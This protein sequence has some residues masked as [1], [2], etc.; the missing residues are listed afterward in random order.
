MDKTKAQLVSVLIPS[1][2]HSKYIVEC[3]ESIKS[4]DYSLLELIVI[5]D[6]STDVSVDIINSWLSCNKDYFERTVFVQQKNA[7]ICKTLNNLIAL[8]QG[9]FLVF[10]ASD[11][12]ILPEGISQRVAAL[13]K[14]ISW[15]AVYGDCTLIDSNSEIISKSAMSYLYKV[16]KLAL[17]NSNYIAREL[18]LNWSVPGPGFMAKKECY[19][20]SRGVGLYNEDL[21]FEDRD[22]YLRLLSKNALG[23]IDFSVAAYRLHGFNISR[24]TKVL[25]LS[26]RMIS[27]LHKSNIQLIKEFHGF[28]QFCLKVVTFYCY[29]TSRFLENKNITNLSMR[30]AAKTI[31]LIVYKI[32]SVIVRFGVRV[33]DSSKLVPSRMK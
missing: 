17:L 1:Y 32:H 33:S 8:A 16:N 12:K 29:Y 10:I 27:A 13:Q 9:D 4:C 23:F 14:N 2:N 22:Y 3:L 20:T 5:D 11:D 19:D 28:T 18:I 24:N 6:G 7:G 21:I 30:I 26:P 31:T 15:L 25:K